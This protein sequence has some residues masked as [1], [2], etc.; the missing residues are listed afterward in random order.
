MKQG[1]SVDVLE[2]VK[3]KT[4]GL[5][6]LSSENNRQRM[7]NLGVSTLRTGKPRS[8]E[9]V[10]DRLGAVTNEDIQSVAEEMFDSNKIAFTVL[11]VSGSE[12]G[13]LEALIS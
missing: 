8:V 2:T 3:H 13:G 1:L 6:I 5:Y 7:H 10:V 9:D 12:A 11:G 4:I